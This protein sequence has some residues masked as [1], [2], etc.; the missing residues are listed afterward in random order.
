MTASPIRATVWNEFIH[1]KSNP[2]V[3]KIYPDGIHAAIAQGL[4]D[5]LKDQIQVRT[6]IL[7]EPEH[8]LTD[9]VLKQTDVLLW[10]GHAAHDQVSDAIVDRVQRHVLAGMGLIVLHSGHGSKIFQRL[11]GTGCMLRWREAGERERIW[12]TA[13]GHPILSGLDVDFI[14]LE[15]AEMYGE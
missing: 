6:A 11:M 1:E 10:W 9:Q 13:P 2:T 3:R 7:E 5:Q 15:Q 14:E 4:E 12:F 8:G